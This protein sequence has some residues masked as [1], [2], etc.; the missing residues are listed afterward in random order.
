MDKDEIA[1]SAKRLTEISARLEEIE[2]A[3]CESKAM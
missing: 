1:E 3:T 2:S